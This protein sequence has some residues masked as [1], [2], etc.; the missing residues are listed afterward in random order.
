MALQ[1][2]Q[3][4]RR[5]AGSRTGE[6]TQQYV[7]LAGSVRQPARIHDEGPAPAGPSFL[8]E[9]GKS[10]AAVATSSISKVER[11][12]TSGRKR[13]MTTATIAATMPTQ[14]LAAMASETDS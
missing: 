10:H 14:K 11:I 12:G 6:L 1:G 3:D 4:R 9:A 7:G 2:G 8:P 5:I 13:T